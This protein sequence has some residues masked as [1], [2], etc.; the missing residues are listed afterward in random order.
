METMCRRNVPFNLI[1][2]MKKGNECSFVAFGVFLRLSRQIFERVIAQVCY[3]SSVERLCRQDPV[4][5][6]KAHGSC[7]NA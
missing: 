3:D 5:L 6:P 4:A 7:A 1:R 2:Q